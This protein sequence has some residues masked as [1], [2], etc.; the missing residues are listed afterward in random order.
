MKKRRNL[1]LSLIIILLLGVSGY[2]FLDTVRAKYKL[3]R[4]KTA[5]SQANY[6]EAVKLLGEASTSQG[7]KAESVFNL[8]PTGK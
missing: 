2:W 1:T 4:G 7:A 5:Y 8:S 3:S 6:D